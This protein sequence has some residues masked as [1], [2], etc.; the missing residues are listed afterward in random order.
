[1]KSPKQI[2]IQSIK[3]EGKPILHLYFMKDTSD[4]DMPF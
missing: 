1:M 4:Q 3:N 2:N